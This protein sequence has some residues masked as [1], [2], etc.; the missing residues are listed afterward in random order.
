MAE[1]KKNMFPPGIEP[2]TLRVWGARDN[3]YTTETL[4]SSTQRAQ[5]PDHRDE[6]LVKI[7]KPGVKTFFINSNTFPKDQQF[8]TDRKNALREVQ[9]KWKWN[10][11]TG[12]KAKVMRIRFSHDRVNPLETLS[13][14]LG[15][16]KAPKGTPIDLS[17]TQKSSQEINLA[18]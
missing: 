17:Y 4:I 14:G 10:S 12:R 1:E 6:E 18:I 9:E 3:H 2:G 11:G 7:A 15:R 13:Q 5:N 16:R 8:K